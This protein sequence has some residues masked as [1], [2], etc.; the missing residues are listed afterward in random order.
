MIMYFAKLGY[1]F[2][3]ELENLNH[4]NFFISGT[5]VQYFNGLIDLDCG[6][7]PETLMKINCLRNCYKNI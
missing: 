4:D 5:M 2:K 6:K 7:N 1:E 3:K